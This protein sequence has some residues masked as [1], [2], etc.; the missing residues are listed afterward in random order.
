M[1]KLYGP[2]YPRRVIE[3]S[4]RSIPRIEMCVKVDDGNRD[5]ESA[6]HRESDAVVSPQHNREGSLGTN[7]A[8]HF[9]NFV[10]CLRGHG[11][12][13]GHI[14]DVHPVLAFQNRAITV[15]V[16]EAFGKIVIVFLRTL[17]HGARAVALARPSP[18]SFVKG[19]AENSEVGM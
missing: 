12:H 1:R 18:G 8:Y 16:I 15:D 9:R 6:Q 19:N 10:V 4:G 17:A 3:I 14:A 7:L 2:I 13:D 11:G 5:V